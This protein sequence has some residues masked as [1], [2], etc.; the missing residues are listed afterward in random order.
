MLTRWDSFLSHL[1]TLK[2]LLT[3]ILRSE[4]RPHLCGEVEKE[5]VELGT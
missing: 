4:V 2:G 3:F 5:K 1:L